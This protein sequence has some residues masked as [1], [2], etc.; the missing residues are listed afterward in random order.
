MIAG[1]EVD[2]VPRAQSAERLNGGGELRDAA[3]N[4][5]SGDGNQVRFERVGAR[6]DLLHERATY[7]RTDVDVGQLDDPEPV[8]LGRQPIERDAHATHFDRLTDRSEG[9]GGQTADQQTGRRRGEA[10][11]RRP[12]LGIERRHR[13]DAPSDRR[14]ET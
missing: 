14:N 6:H 11:Q 4:E 7:R 12:P 9:D 2:A 10:G 1:H 3:V 8:L 13:R 5:I